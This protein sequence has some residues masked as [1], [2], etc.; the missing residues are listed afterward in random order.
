MD[1]LVI[2]ALTLFYALTSK[3]VVTEEKVLKR[4]TR[5]NPDFYENP[6]AFTEVSSSLG[7]H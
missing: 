6:T 1:C 4:E 2:L 5:L 3:T 7:F